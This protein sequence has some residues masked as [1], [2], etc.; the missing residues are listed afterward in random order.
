MKMAELNIKLNKFAEG[1]DQLRQAHK[2]CPGKDKVN[3][4]KTSCAGLMVNLLFIN[5][6]DNQ[7]C[8]DWNTLFNL[9]QHTK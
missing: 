3:T 6:F 7:T 4:C 5:Q 2:R 9:K 8:F 1:V